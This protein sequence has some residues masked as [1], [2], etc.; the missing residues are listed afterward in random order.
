MMSYS[1]LSPGLTVVAAAKVTSSI[2]ALPLWSHLSKTR[3]DKL[4]DL[5]KSWRAEN[6]TKTLLLFPQGSSSDERVVTQF[7]EPS[8]EALEA[9]TMIVPVA[10]KLTSPFPLNFRCLNGNIVLDFVIGMAIPFFTAEMKVFPP[11]KM[12][13]FSSSAEAADTIGRLIASGFN[14]PYLPIPVFEKFKY[15]H[16]MRDGHFAQLKLIHF[17]QGNSNVFKAFYIPFSFLHFIFQVH[18]IILIYAVLVA[19]EF[20]PLLLWS[21]GGS[22]TLS[23]NVITLLKYYFHTPRPIWI[24]QTLPLTKLVWE[25]DYSFPSGHSGMVASI[26]GGILFHFVHSRGMSYESAFTSPAVYISLFITIITGFSRCFTGMHFVTDVLAG[27]ALGIGTAAVWVTTNADVNF[28]LQTI[29]NPQ[30]ILALVFASAFALALLYIALY[31]RLQGNKQHLE[32]IEYWNQ[33]IEAMLDS[34]SFENK[35]LVESLRKHKIEANRMLT[36]YYSWGVV[37]GTFLTAPLQMLL[38]PENFDVR[39][40]C[41]KDYSLNI[42]VVLVGCALLILL[43]SRIKRSLVATRSVLFAV[44]FLWITMLS[45]RLIHSIQGLYQ[46]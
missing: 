24:D 18:S 7:M 25:N 11:V 20:D 26:F 13:E 39:T 12:S 17:L 1:Q 36:V 23:H 41:A 29:R 30:F 45:K 21:L 6:P 16:K 35:K 8:F 19:V 22:V 2:F 46:C 9:S 33:N 14:K 28:I 42:V 3:G 38:G 40:E 44:V 34:K 10:K 4:V 15:E 43:V 32:R 5:L 31:M 37:V 27:W